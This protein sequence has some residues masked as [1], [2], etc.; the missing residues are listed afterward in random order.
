MS[1]EVEIINREVARRFTPE[2]NESGII[3]IEKIP[4]LVKTLVSVRSGM[5][6]YIE[7]LHNKLDYII[8]AT[9]WCDMCECT[10]CTSD[11]R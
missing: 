2:W 7:A 3:N 6:D 8:E 1:K 9:D 10:G 5:T 11:H 4:D